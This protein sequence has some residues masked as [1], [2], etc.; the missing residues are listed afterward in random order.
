MNQ[1]WHLEW[2]RE[3]Q[4]FG[5]RLDDSLLDTL[6]MYILCQLRTMS[7]A[8]AACYG[9]VDERVRKTHVLSVCKQVDLAHNVSF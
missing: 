2:W 8:A 9:P 5:T 6:E 7:L 1:A 3:R 4:Q